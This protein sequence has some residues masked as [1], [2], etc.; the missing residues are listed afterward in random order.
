MERGR[1]RLLLRMGRLHFLAAGFLL[2]S[3]GALFALTSGA[4]FD[5]WRFALGYLV[6][7]AGHLS[8]SYSNEYFDREGDRFARP[9]ATSGGSG[10]LVA[11][12]DFAP[13]ALRCAAGLIVLSLAAAVLYMRLYPPGGAVFA[14][15]VAGNLLGW[16]YSA[17]PL[18]LVARGWGEAAT[19]AGIGLLVPGMGYLT[20]A[21]RIDPAF[22]LF[23][24][25]LFCY[26]FFFIM[27]VEVP[28]IEADRRAEKLTLAARRGPEFARRVILLSALSATLCFVGWAGRYPGAPVFA[29]LSLIPLA[30][31]GI[32]TVTWA[33]SARAAGNLLALTAFCMLADAFLLVTL[34]A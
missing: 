10:V 27:S 21:G 16:F 30:T 6:L 5:P 32:G 25:P 34:P 8:V 17:P 4:A 13:E 31:A 18:R 15:A 22:A 1:W 33:P 2:F 7:G 19:A 20:L 9:T 12:P 23:S 24:L 11:R 26:G 29:V 14:A 28:D 3:L